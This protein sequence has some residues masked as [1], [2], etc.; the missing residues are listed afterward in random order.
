MKIFQAVQ[1]RLVYDWR[2]ASKW[3]SV[4]L[5][6]GGAA[7][8]GAIALGL[9]MSAAATQWASIIPMWAVFL[10]AA[11]IFGL[12]VLSRVWDQPKL[13][14]PPDNNAEHA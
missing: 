12:V 7:L 5:A 1:N 14:E 3:W 9:S 11:I 8:F 13:R 6:G 2:S 4:R 10:L